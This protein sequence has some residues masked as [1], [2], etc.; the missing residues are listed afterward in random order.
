MDENY[1]QS[2]TAVASQAVLSLSNIST[3]PYL[4]PET[5]IDQDN[6]IFCAKFPDQDYDRSFQNQRRPYPA[7]CH[8]LTK[9]TAQL[10]LVLSQKVKNISHSADRPRN[11]ETYCLPS[12][13]LAPSS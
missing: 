2:G 10:R 3:L 11:S 9:V 5:F 13:S 12:K 6:F 7:C 1:E 4:Q 8:T